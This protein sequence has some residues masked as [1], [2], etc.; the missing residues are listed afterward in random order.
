MAAGV[1]FPP[2]P[3]SSPSSDSL[4]AVT[5][6]HDDAGS[7]RACLGPSSASGDP[8]GKQKHQEYFE[9]YFGLGPGRTL[10]KLAQLLVDDP[11]TDM[12]S[13]G[14]TLRS[15]EDMSP[16]YHWQEQV[17][18][19]V[20]QRAK[21]ID[22]EV[23]EE[24]LELLREF[25]VAAR[26]DMGRYIRQIQATRKSKKPVMIENAGDLDRIMRLAMSSAGTPVAERVEHTGKDGGPL[27]H[28]LRLR[29][30]EDL[31][32]EELQEFLKQNGSEPTESDGKSDGGPDEG[33]GAEPGD[34]AA[35]EAGTD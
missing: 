4:T 29:E 9:L 33:D 23:K 28:D 13:V 12:T 1:L 24:V 34:R 35:E 25:V 15:L 14:G 11:G 3:H 20:D 8:V 16:K 26:T 2:T 21:E 27:E 32:D 22:D 19:R 18:Q 10:Q 31:T 7:I 17:R 5:T 6:Q 30:W